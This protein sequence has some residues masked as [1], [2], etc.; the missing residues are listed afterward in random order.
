MLNSTFDPTEVL[1]PET[2]STLSC[3]SEKKSKFQTYNPE[4]L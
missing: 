1:M 4:F 2:K 3:I